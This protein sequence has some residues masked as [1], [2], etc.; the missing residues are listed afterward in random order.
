MMHCFLRIRK[1]SLLFL[2]IMKHW[3]MAHIKWVKNQDLSGIKYRVSH[4]PDENFTTKPPPHRISEAP[5][6]I[7]TSLDLSLS[8]CIKQ[9]TVYDF[10]DIWKWPIFFNAKIGINHA[11][12]SNDNVIIVWSDPRMHCLLFRIVLRLVKVKW[13]T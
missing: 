7:L 4:F 11:S 13:I 9:L 1:P 6:I 5:R 12:Q 2:L 3:L 8:R 10:S